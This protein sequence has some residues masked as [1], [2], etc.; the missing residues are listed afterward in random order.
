MV[1][2]K[3][4]AS[5]VHCLG[6]QYVQTL[7]CVTVNDAHQTAIHNL[8]VGRTTSINDDDIVRRLLGTYA[9]QIARKRRRTLN[10][11]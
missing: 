5:Q 6:W 11:I 3:P 7:Y 8:T 1:S 10:G 2:V 4:G 9:E